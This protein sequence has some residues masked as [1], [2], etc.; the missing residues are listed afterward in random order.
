[1]AQHLA[2][3]G[4]GTYRPSGVYASTETAITDTALPTVDRAIVIT[5]YDSAD[6]DRVP[7]VTLSVQVRTRGTQDP[8]VCAAL[9]DAVYAALHATG[10]HYWGA[11][12]VLL[13]RRDSAAVL[14]PDGQGRH[15]RTSNYVLRALRDLPQ[16]AP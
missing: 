2:D 3:A 7:D 4:A 10:P 11:A 12:T 16:L 1:M 13:I 8:R 9:D 6:S 5:V 15:E 14:G